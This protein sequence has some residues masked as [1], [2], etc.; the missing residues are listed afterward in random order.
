MPSGEI[1]NERLIVTIEARTK[2]RDRERDVAKVI[3]FASRQRTT[4]R[5]NWPHNTLHLSELC[6]PRLQW[7]LGGIDRVSSTTYQRNCNVAALRCSV[8]CHPS[9]HR[10]G[11]M[12]PRQV[13]LMLSRV[14]WRLPQS[15][16]Y[17]LGDATVLCGWPRMNDGRSVAWRLRAA[18]IIETADQ[19]V[20]TTEVLPDCW[21]SEAMWFRLTVTVTLYNWNY[22]CKWKIIS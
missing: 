6:R 7:E 1:E 11:L 19:R 15:D 20:K 2:Q 9:W 12:S 14:R 8:Y 5:R 22:S 3:F 4:R 13:A 18:S 10:P 16:S 21:R 17:G